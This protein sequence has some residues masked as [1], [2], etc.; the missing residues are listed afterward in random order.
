MSWNLCRK[1]ATEPEER[2]RDGT[3]PKEPLSKRTRSGGSQAM[4]FN[5]RT[6]QLEIIEGTS[7][8]T[9]RGAGA[10]RKG[11]RRGRGAP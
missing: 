9:S 4:R 3:G 2:G 8:A 5:H 7:A 6:H 11:G 10:G 1:A